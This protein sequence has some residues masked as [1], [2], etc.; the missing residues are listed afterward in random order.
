MA[1]VSRCSAAGLQGIDDE[2]QG[3]SVQCHPR[4]KRIVV[5][6][7]E[8]M[9]LMRWSPDDAKLPALVGLDSNQWSAEESERQMRAQPRV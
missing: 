6:V 4:K 5:R 7:E 1:L 3:A 8:R 9:P 2:S